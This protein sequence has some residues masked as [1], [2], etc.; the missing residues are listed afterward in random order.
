M[1]TKPLTYLISLSLSLASFGSAEAQQPS[2]RDVLSFLVTNQA[3]PT[4][5]LVKDQEAAAATRDTIARA[6]LIELT[7]LPLAT[8][9]GAFT[10]RL[11]PTL[12][13]L[14]RLAQSF[15][16]FLVDRAVTTGRGQISVASMFRYAPITTLDGRD[17]RDGT[18][19]TTANQF[20]DEPEP[21]DV[22]ALT[23]RAT[24]RTMTV[25]GN[26]GVTDW[27]DVGAA[28]PYVWFEMSGER[29]NTYRGAR[30]VQARATASASGLGDIAL[31]AKARVAGTGVSGVAAGL[32]VRLP[33]GDPEDLN[34]AGSTAVKGS[35]IGS[36][37][38]G[39]FDL[40]VN[41]GLTGGGISQETSLGAAVAFAATPRITLSAETIVRRLNELGEITDVATRHPTL[42]G[43]D[44]L[45]LLP[46]GDDAVTS[47]LLT[48]VRWNLARTYLVSAHVLFPLTDRGLG[49]RP[50]PTV[51][52]D[53][54]FTR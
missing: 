11:N 19:V 41:A 5:D 30:V 50:V 31:R 25:F 29:V 26:V 28:V 43:V 42:A 14:D 13:T 6:L 18:L 20:Q 40:H 47:T 3:V 22:E 4:A 53:Y 24:T 39:P 16:P 49:V 54:L 48:G 44:T 2:V 36:L 9:S 51:S 45:R 38:A 1:P 21:F 12:G 7:T 33:T 34:G 52:I 46:V 27:L 35:V 17:L 32:E 15:G 8:S 23:L 37:G 10:Y